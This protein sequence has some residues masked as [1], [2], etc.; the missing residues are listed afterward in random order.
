MAFKKYGYY[1]KGNKIAVVEQAD[2][3]ASGTLAVAHCTIGGYST[4]DTCEAAG[5]QWIPGSSGSTTNY[6]EYMSP[7]ETVTDGL[8]IQYAYSPTY[9]FPDIQVRGDTLANHT[10]FFLNGWTVVDGYLTLLSTAK[11]WSLFTGVD[12]NDNI[13]IGNSERWN[14]LHKIQEIETYLGSAPIKHSAIKTYTKVTDNV[15]YVYDSDVNWNADTTNTISDFSSSSSLTTAFI[16]NITTPY[17]WISADSSSAN[18]GLFSGWTYSGTTLDLSSATRYHRP[19]DEVAETE[20]T[21]SLVS[22]TNEDIYI[23]KAYHDP[24]M[25]FITD[26][27]VMEDETFELDITRYQ[28]NAVV[29]YLKAKVAED[30]GDLEKREFFFREFKRQVE[31]G[32]SAYKSGPYIVQGFKEMR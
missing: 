2:S 6:G 16:D 30:M 14:G 8:E 13:Y 5:G 21:V 20:A 9:T 15:T 26:V 11:H 28:A 19:Y 7:T 3:T 18:V 25:Y 17:L 32:N 31:K 27:A 1:I 4:K 12:V 24:S 22:D 10:K 23:Y 29:Y